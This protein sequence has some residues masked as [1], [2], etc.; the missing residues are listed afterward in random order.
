MTEWKQPRRTLLKSREK[1]VMIFSDVHIP[2]HCPKAVKTMLSFM[3][4]FKPDQIVING[5]FMDFSGIS[6]HA[7]ASTASRLTGELAQGNDFLDAVRQTAPRA[8]V[9]FDEGNHET[10]YEKFISRQAPQ[11]TGLTSVYR[12]L[13]MRE[14]GINYMPYGA[15]NVR[16]IAPKLGV[17]HGSFF[18]SHYTQQTINKYGVSIIVGH[19]HRPQFSSIP[20]VGSTGQQVRAC[21][22]LGCLVPVRNVRYLATPSGWTQGWGVA[23]ISPNGEFNVQQINLVNG[24]VT[25][26][27][28]TRTK[29]Y[30]A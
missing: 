27:D 19:A 24:R 14:R 8:D 16:F 1:R 3:R 5:D 30:G 2:N 18:G 15:D 11:L 25:V 6:R 12:E 13:R 21:W 29:T 26:P 20:T 4:D 28:F 23:L 17:T 7:D 9:D 10:N 22:G